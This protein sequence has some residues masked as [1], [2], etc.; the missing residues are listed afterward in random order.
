MAPHP[1]KKVSGARGAACS[2]TNV[3]ERGCP[4]AP[5]VFLAFVS[6][7]PRAGARSSGMAALGIDAAWLAALRL[8][9]LGTQ[10][11]HGGVIQLILGGT[12]AE[13]FVAPARGGMVRCRGP[14]CLVLA[15][16]GVLPGALP[17]APLQHMSVPLV[18]FH[19][20]GGAPAPAR[21]HDDTQF[22][23][24]M[25]PARAHRF[26]CGPRAVLAPGVEVAVPPL[27]LAPLRIRAPRVT[28]EAAEGALHRIKGAL[29]ALNELFDADAPKVLINGE[30]LARWS[31]FQAVQSIDAGAARGVCGS[32]EEGELVC[33]ALG[34]GCA[35]VGVYVNGVACGSPLPLV[36]AELARAAALPAT[37][38]SE[39]TV[40]IAIYSV[41]ATFEASDTDLGG[42]RLTSP[43]RAFSDARSFVTVQMGEVVRRWRATRRGPPAA[44]VDAPAET[45]TPLGAS[46]EPDSAVPA[47]AAP[48][49]R[50]APASDARQNTEEA[51]A[52][53][54]A[55]PGARREVGV[56]RAAPPPPGP[57]PP[58]PPVPRPG[59]L[60]P[61][62]VFGPR[63]PP[64]RGAPPPR[65]TPLQR[66]VLGAPL[67][68][69]VTSI[70][71][72]GSVLAPR[73]GSMFAPRAV[74]SA[75]LGVP[76]TGVPRGG[77]PGATAPP[78]RPVL[79]PPDVARP[80]LRAAGG[81]HGA[82]PPA[83]IQALLNNPAR[84]VVDAPR[85]AAALSDDSSSD[86]SD[87]DGAEEAS[88]SSGV[89][90]TSGR[91]SG[92]ATSSPDSTSSASGSSDASSGDASGVARD[93]DA[94]SE[95]GASAPTSSS[96]VPRVLDNGDSS[97][98]GAG[99]PRDSPGDGTRKH[100][101]RAPAQKRPRE[102][103]HE[104][105]TLSPKRAREE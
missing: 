95:S 23:V 100:S 85:Q 13:V 50:S 15:C 101:E 25:A 4:P 78:F 52:T 57:A 102:A 93:P 88:D 87:F 2:G 92:S 5:Q 64:G 46:R 48:P 6:G 103:G 80:A 3:P 98:G 99:E 76:V 14:A 94:L 96:D 42:W 58:A 10:R 67:G 39:F 51:R 8:V 82:A 86:D 30:E 89:T 44:P 26:H 56:P 62:T 9:T 28:T 7:V 17:G 73:G 27:P 91:S 59:A 12:H 77:A 81:A 49:A 35:N 60:A 53:L 68:A 1:P 69:P 47:R 84:R 97:G 104:D 74:Q 34:F 45:A 18:P 21:A 11:P 79:R 90:S 33:V 66:G 70:P 38:L 72:G 55:A 29:L 71:R 37:A 32:V 41:D 19:A 20:I 36:A 75:P 24:L 105:A 31:A 65:G 40:F 43:L 16:G 63:A 54:H 61:G 83:E 22:W